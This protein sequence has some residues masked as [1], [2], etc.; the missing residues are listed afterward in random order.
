MSSLR[1]RIWEAS[2]RTP[3]TDDTTTEKATKANTATFIIQKH[4]YFNA[5][6]G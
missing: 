2:N 3:K 5:V 1:Q 4:A 6:L